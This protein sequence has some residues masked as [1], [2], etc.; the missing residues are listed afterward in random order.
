LH[1]DVAIGR[2][3]GR[4]TAL[5]EQDVLGRL[6]PLETEG[7]LH[8]SRPHAQLV[9]EVHVEVGV[10]ED[11]G[12][13]AKVG[14]DEEVEV[15]GDGSLKLRAHAPK[16]ELVRD[17]VAVIGKREPAVHLHQRGE[18]QDE[19]AGLRLQGESVPVAGHERRPGGRRR[20]GARRRLRRG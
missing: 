5:H 3:E 9:G 7:A 19:V 11:G 10:L 12:A 18:L 2:D 1:P 15:P 16:Q 4:Q 8:L 17:Q 20:S 6:Q 13:Q 14:I